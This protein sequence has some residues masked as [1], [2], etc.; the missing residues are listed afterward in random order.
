MSGS[1]RKLA[2]QT[3]VYG[4]STVLVK[5]LN[6]LLV[7]YLTRVMGQEAY[8][9]V[10]H[11]YGIIPLAL[12]LLTMGLESG[13]FRFAGKAA[14]D[15]R[16]QDVFATAW[17]MVAMASAAFLILVVLFLNPISRAIGYDTHPSF[18]WMTA[19]IIAVDAFTAVPFARLRERQ[20]AGRYVFLRLVSVIVNLIFCFFFYGWLPK[21]AANGI[22]T[23]LYSPDMGPGY[24]FAANL[25]ASFVTMLLIL[26]MCGRTWPKINPSLARQILLYSLPLLL[27]GIAG[28]ANEF[29]DRQMVLWFIPASPDVALQQLGIYGAVL[30]L[31]VVM[32]LFTSM[33][34]LAAEPFFLAEFKADDFRK[35]NAEAM[36][37]F[38]IVSIFI[39]LV[40]ALFSDLFALILGRDF[41]QGVHILPL[42]L[43]AN[44]FSGIVL[45]L[46]FWYKQS[47]ATKFAIYITGLGLVF[48]VILNIVLVPVW[49]YVGAATA[50]LVC[51]IVMVIFSYVLNR[52][53]CPVPYDLPRIGTYFLFGAAL[54]GIGVACI[55]LPLW[56]RYL[57]CFALVVIFALCS[58]KK[59]HIDLTGILRRMV[60]RK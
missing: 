1:I 37:Y 6:Y 24:V 49:G 15:D 19:A 32:T 34:R 55:H 59:E 52:K 43:L 57:I 26:P 7:P 17:G 56:P 14:S 47:G 42:I 13:Y 25:L 22:L 5:L 31:G 10:T 9:V 39:F 27:S 54:Y 33:Y 28:T 29:I 48:T 58:L 2:G 3:V 35:T 36:K 53:Y 12:V 60:A 45:N 41:R 20:Q 4:V 21:L 46:S 30:R 18:V 40:I 11:I 38:I 16:R 8:G 51:E 50:R 23:S 44:M